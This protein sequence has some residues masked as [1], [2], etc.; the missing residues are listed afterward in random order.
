MQVPAFQVCRSPICFP[1]AIPGITVGGKLTCYQHGIEI[2]KEN[3]VGPPSPL[4]LFQRGAVRGLTFLL[5]CPSPSC[6]RTRPSR[7]R[8]LVPH[9]SP[10]PPKPLTTSWGSFPY[11]H[12]SALLQKGFLVLPGSLNKYL[13]HLTSFIPPSC[14]DPPCSVVQG[15]Q[16][17]I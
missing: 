3:P 16:P 12:P 6:S 7:P 15:Q 11:I 10:S 14:Y 1:R 4:R 17:Q 2:R 9:C 13:V 5:C 8:C